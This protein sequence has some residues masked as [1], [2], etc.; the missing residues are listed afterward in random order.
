MEVSE[1]SDSSILNSYIE[2]YQD[3]LQLLSQQRQ[4]KFRNAVMVQSAKGEGAAPVDQVAEAQAV[5]INTRNQTKPLVPTTHDRRWVYPISKGWGDICD[6]IDKLKIN[7][8]LTGAYTQTGIAAINREIDDEVIRGFFADANTGRSGGTTTSFPAGNVV[9][10]GEGASAATG[11]NVDKL[12]AARELIMANDVDIDD[13]MNQLYCAISP[14]QERDLLE[15]VKVTNT[16]YQ[17]N[18]ILSGNGKGLN[19]WFGI[20]FIISTRL[21]ADG[22]SYRRNPF[23]CKGGMN[24]SF[25]TDVTANIKQRDDLHRDPYHVEVYSTFGA[26]R[27][28]EDK[29]I[30]IKCSEA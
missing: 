9:A 15:Q 14:A 21:D 13:P 17:D 12:L 6:E 28:E 10:V 2:S 20:N 22:N 11:M 18:A 19:R 23:W 3:N 7:I 4:S 16:D 8:E 24:L 29:V 27:I 30:E 25:W 5:D 1:M 26:T